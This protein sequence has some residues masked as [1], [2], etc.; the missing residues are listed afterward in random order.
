MSVNNGREIGKEL[1]R[2]YT[3]IANQIDIITAEAK[4]KKR[5]PLTIRNM[6]GDYI[7]IPLLLAKAQILNALTLVNQR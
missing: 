5:D 7:L 6:N 1:S 3:Q 2:T 4:D